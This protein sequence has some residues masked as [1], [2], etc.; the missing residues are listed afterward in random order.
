MTRNRLATLNVAFLAAIAIFCPAIALGQE[1]R[2]SLTGLVTDSSGA[3]VP[4]ATVTVTNVATQV[5]STATTNNA[6]NYVLLF[7]L[8]GQYRVQVEAS[9]F[10]QFVRENITLSTSE[11]GTLDVTL[12]LGQLTESV[13]VTEAAPLLET[14][15]ASRSNVVTGQ[16]MTD[17]PSNSRN[18]YNVILALPGVQKHDR[19]WGAFSNYGL[20][21]STRLSI[22]GGIA[23]ENE[24]VMDGVVNTQPDRTITF[25]PPLEAVSE[26]N[27]QT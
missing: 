13:N 2:A 17:L 18:I 16:Q 25:Q 14:A 26:V 20:I 19:S 1:L 7:L 11:R 22:N 23:R 8:P 21:N 24:A 9:G 6:G 4:N 12:Q 3:T 10:K 15:T 5:V 27:V